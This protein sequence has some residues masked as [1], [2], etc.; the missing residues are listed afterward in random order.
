MNCS[1]YIYIDSVVTE[2]GRLGRVV[3]SWVKIIQG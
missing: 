1:R 2:F 3:E